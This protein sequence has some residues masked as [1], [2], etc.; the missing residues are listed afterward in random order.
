MLTATT[1]FDSCDF[2][3]AVHLLSSMSCPFR[4][5][6]NRNL[7]DDPEFSDVVSELHQRVLDYIQ[8][9]PIS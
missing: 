2:F 9:R 4:P 8:L 5:G 1:E 7:V 3:C 6:E